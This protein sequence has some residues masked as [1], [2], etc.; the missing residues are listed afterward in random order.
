MRR[1]ITICCMFAIVGGLAFGVGMREGD[2]AQSEEAA[3]EELVA[4]VTAG[5]DDW[6]GKSDPTAFAQ[7]FADKATYFDPWSGGRLE[8]G[9]IKEY[10]MAFMGQV[11]EL[12]FEI[13]NPKVDL[14]G[15]TAVLTFLC[16]AIDP[17]SGAV[18]PWNVTEIFTRTR[19]GWERVHSN[20]NYREGAPG[21]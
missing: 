9:A 2:T 4:I 13:P 16:N 14:Y 3:L 5:L 20:W 19:N 15:D 1:F 8:D 11:P 18:T 6:Y 21:S 12:H 17:S 7:A 10:L